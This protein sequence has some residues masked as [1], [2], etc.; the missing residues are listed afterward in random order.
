[1]KVLKCRR[2]K[3]EQRTNFQII[4]VVDNYKRSRTFKL[5][6][7]TKPNQTLILSVIQEFLFVILRK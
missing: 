6:R 5:V 1:M 4:V 3:I 2:W 7:D